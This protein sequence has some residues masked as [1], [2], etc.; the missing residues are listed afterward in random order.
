MNYDRISGAVDLKLLKDTHIVGVGS[1]GA[2]C[3][4]EALVRSGIG[5]L[6]VLDIDTV[7][8]V[9]LCRQGFYPDQVGDDKVDALAEHLYRINPNLEYTGLTGNFLDMEEWELDSIF[10]KADLF[11]FLTDSFPAQSFGN[12]L[13]LRYNKPAIWGGFYAASQ[14]AEIVFYIPEVTPA[15][16]RCVVASRY[17][18]QAKAK[19]EIKVSSNCNT[20]FHSQML[21]SMIG[22][23]VLAILHNDRPGYTF[24][25]YFEAPWV[26]N[27]IQFKVSPDY[28]S[29]LFDA[30]TQNTEGRGLLFN[31]IWQPILRDGCPDC[32]LQE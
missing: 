29:Q 22:M 4:Y 27:L 3:L 13:A 31:A 11:L 8:D 10:G 1:G 9:N 2:Y 24:S 23:L 6:T 7:D 28:E 32:T 19:E 25:N 18:A 17:E 5:K 14:C 30:L 15:C 16:F 20:M 21:D 26:Q 12:E